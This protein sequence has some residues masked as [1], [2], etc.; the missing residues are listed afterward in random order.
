M[1]IRKPVLTGMVLLL[2]L[3]LYAFYSTQSLQPFNEPVAVAVRQAAPD[4][5]AQPTNAAETAVTVLRDNT[6]D[7][8][9]YR[10]GFDGFPAVEISLRDR[11]DMAVIPTTEHFGDVYTEWVGMAESGDPAF[12]FAVDQALRQGKRSHASSEDLEEAV[13]LVHSELKHR[14][15]SGEPDSMIAGNDLNE[16]EEGMRQ[17]FK[18]CSGLPKDEAR[19]YQGDWLQKSAD[20][21]LF[22]ALAVMGQVKISEGKTAEAIHYV[23][24]A[25]QSGSHSALRQLSTFYA[26]GSAEHSADPILSAAY[27]H[28]DIEIFNLAFPPEKRGPIVTR[29]YASKE[30]QLHDKLRALRPHEQGK[31][32][33]Q[34]HQILKRNPKCCYGL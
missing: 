25:W 8:G 34:A 12:A 26:S 10:I 13:A 18:Y 21:G 19:N 27:L 6:A 1:S 4:E 16:V 28:L 7:D 3:L 22:H 29:F 31:V 15:G 11:S 9:S 32:L 5:L 17:L 24:R 23:E 20:K 30:Q 2:I 33:Q 14:D